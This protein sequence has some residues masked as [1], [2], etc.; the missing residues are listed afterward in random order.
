MKERML[1]INKSLD[2]SFFTIFYFST[3]YL[4]ILQLGKVFD[5]GQHT[6]WA[7]HSL[8]FPA[9]IN[10]QPSFWASANNKESPSLD[11]PHILFTNITERY[12]RNTNICHLCSLIFHKIYQG[13]NNNNNMSSSST[14]CVAKNR[15]SLI[16]KGFAKSHRQIYELIGLL[17]KICRI[18]SLWY[19]FNSVFITNFSHTRSKASLIVWIWTNGSGYILQ[20]SLNSLWLVNINVGCV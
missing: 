13:R 8:T 9:P 7:S 2:L 11:N 10:L 19:L 18:A 17:Y 12:S 16:H 6:N 4:I 20:K 14:H 5:Q 3:K 15:Q 1:I